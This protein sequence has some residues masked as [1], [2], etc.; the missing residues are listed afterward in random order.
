MCFP[1]SGPLQDFLFIYFFINSSL[2][3][4]LKVG[5]YSDMSQVTMSISRTYHVPIQ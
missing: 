4:G 3:P 1:Y 5:F 2:L